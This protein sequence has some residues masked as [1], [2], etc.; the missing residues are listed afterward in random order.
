MR[1]A[2][3]IIY[4]KKVPPN[5]RPYGCKFRKNRS[6]G[7]LGAVYFFI[8]RIRSRINNKVVLNCSISVPPFEGIN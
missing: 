2:N 5:G 3:A 7:K 1:K 8:A 6:A 4:I